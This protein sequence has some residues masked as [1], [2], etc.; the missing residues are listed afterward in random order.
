MT[1]WESVALSRAPRRIARVLP[2]T[3]SADT[4]VTT[5]FA[6]GCRR[7]GRAGSEDS[8]ATRAQTAKEANGYRCDR[9]AH[10]F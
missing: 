10:G 9:V 2:R 5:D 6:A 4:A 3:P 8:T 7:A 1:G